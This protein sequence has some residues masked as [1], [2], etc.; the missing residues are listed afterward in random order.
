M[1]PISLETL[2]E[3]HREG[4]DS[5][6]EF[7]R[8]SSMS[9]GLYRIPAGEPDRQTPHAEDEVYV[10]TAGRASIEIGGDTYPV[11]EGDVVFVERGVEHR[12]V[13]IEA[14]LETLVLFAPPEGTL[15]ADR[16]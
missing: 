9:A 1:E 10:V 15:D 16:E 6:L 5:Y 13:D 7:L 12:F 2:R 8:E 11:E 3:R 14:D 4:G